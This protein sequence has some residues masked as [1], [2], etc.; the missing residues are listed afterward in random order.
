[1]KTQKKIKVSIC[2]YRSENQKKSKNFNKPKK[3]KN[4][5]NDSVGPK[6]QNQ[7][8]SLNR[9]KNPKIK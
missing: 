1:M 4:K 8:K 2:F 9:S 3:I 7:N 6:I 5:I